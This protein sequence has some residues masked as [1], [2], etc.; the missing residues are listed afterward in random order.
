MGRTTADLALKVNLTEGSVAA[1]SG[2]VLGPRGCWLRAAA[3]RGATS[4]VVAVVSASRRT[5]CVTAARVRGS[6]ARLSPSSASES[7]MTMGS[8]R[9][10]DSAISSRSMT[11]VT[12]L[13]AAAVAAAAVA[14][15]AAVAAAAAGWARRRG[16]AAGVTAAAG[17]GAGAEAGAARALALEDELE[18]DRDPDH[19][20]E[21][22]PE[23]ERR[24][25]L[26]GREVD[27]LR[28]LLPLLLLLLL[29]LPLRSRLAARP[30]GD[31]RRPAS[32]RALTE[33]FLGSLFSLRESL[34]CLGVSVVSAAGLGRARSAASGRAVSA[35]LV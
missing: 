13:G 4:A 35:L 25:Y 1:G 32:S 26:R 22:L 11:A 9:G 8:V 34:R 23:R 33:P 7:V 20:L 24:A 17:A 21:P 30:G 31:S 29:L 3:D 16:A 2:G 6:A 15:V 12:E 10:G 19:E 14:A 5:G 18:L 27:R 28:L